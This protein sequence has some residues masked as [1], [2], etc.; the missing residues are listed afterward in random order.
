MPNF[1][2]VIRSLVPSVTGY[3][4]NLQFLRLFLS[5][6]GPYRVL[7]FSI[8]LQIF[9]LRNNVYKVARKVWGK[10]GKIT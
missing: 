2:K 6:D 4:A 10:N 8:L 9:I 5:V 1:L 7:Q 3:K